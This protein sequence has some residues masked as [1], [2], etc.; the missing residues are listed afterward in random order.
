MKTAKCCIKCHHK[1][2][3]HARN[4][5]GRGAGNASHPMAIGRSG[6]I[7]AEDFGQ[8]EAYVCLGCGYT[9]FYVV[10][11]AELTPLGANDG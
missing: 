6:I 9:E 10:D 1:S 7:H 8:L 4:V 5:L 11:P 2:I 3:F